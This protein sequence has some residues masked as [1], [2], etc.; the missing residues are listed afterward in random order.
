MS[1]APGFLEWQQAEDKRILLEGVKKHE[2]AVEAKLIL[3]EKED[4]DNNINSQYYHRIAYNT[5]QAWSSTNFSL[6]KEYDDYLAANAALVAHIN[7]LKSL[8]G[9]SPHTPSE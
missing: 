8:N 9:T 7:K 1:L 2:A 6:G 3:K 5:Y 4:A